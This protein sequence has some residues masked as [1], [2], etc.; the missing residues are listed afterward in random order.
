MFNWLKAFL[1]KIPILRSLKTY[2]FLVMLIMG[3]IPCLN[4]KIAILN[5][6]E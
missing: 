4:M 2:L 3:I 1:M 5:S 6:Y